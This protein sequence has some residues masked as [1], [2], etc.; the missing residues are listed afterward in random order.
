[1]AHITHELIS[2]QQFPNEL[3]YVSSSPMRL[4]CDNPITINIAIK[5]YF[6]RELKAREGLA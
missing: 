1:M 4:Y 3:G 5:P 6:L 2:M